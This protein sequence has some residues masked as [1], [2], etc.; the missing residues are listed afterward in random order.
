MV[1]KR[2]TKKLR[3]AGIEHLQVIKGVYGPYLYDPRVN[4][5]QSV[6]HKTP[7]ACVEAAIK[8]E[9]PSQRGDE[10]NGERTREIQV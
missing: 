4:R 10:K 8:G 5:Q 2:A 6:C 3:D 7:D 9:R 1:Y